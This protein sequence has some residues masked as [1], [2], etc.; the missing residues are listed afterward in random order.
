MRMATKNIAIRE[1]VYKKLLSAKSD[2]ESFSDAI[3]RLLEGK[4]NILSFAGIFG[5]NDPKLKFIE[6]EVLKT[7][8][9]ARLRASP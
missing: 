9:K 7:R 5:K 8:R 3:D 1:E 2:E 6:K 4:S